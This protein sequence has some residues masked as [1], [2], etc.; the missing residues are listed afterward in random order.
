MEC[1]FQSSRV[2]CSMPGHTRL[3]QRMQNMLRIAKNERPTVFAFQHGLAKQTWVP[4]PFEVCMQVFAK[5]CEVMM[6]ASTVMAVDTNTAGM[7]D[8][9]RS[10]FAVALRRCYTAASL[11]CVTTPA[12]KTAEHQWSSGRIHRRH[13][14]DPGMMPG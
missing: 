8:T 10:A 2:M 14:C 5:L 7:P 9:R 3:L 1:V 12:A 13:R 4:K 6:Q 11:S